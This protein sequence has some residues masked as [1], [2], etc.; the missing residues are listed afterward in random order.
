MKFLDH[1]K[2][3]IQSGKGG[4]GCLSFRRE[5][6]IEFGGP[7]GGD[8]GRGGDVWIECVEGLNTLI[9]YRFQQ[10]YKAKTGT[11]GMGKN[12]TGAKGA[13]MVLKVPAG[14]QVYAEDEE[15]LIADLTV[16]GMRKLLATGGN[17]GFGNTRFKSATNRA[18]RRANPGEPSEEFIL[19]LQLK[20]IADA[21]LVGLP[22]A[23]KSTF[24]AAVTSARP[25]IADYP[26]TTLTPNLGVV[27]Y[28]SREFVLADI[29]GLIEGAHEGIGL[30]DQFLAH[31][32]RCSVILHL[33]DG[34]SD[35][36][37]M[38][39]Q[40]IRTE[41][42][43]HGELLGEKTEIVALNK[44]DSLVEEEAEEKA[45]LLTKVAGQPVH[46]LSGVSG[47]GRDDILNILL[48]H[49]EADR[50]AEKRAENAGQEEEKWQP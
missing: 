11:Q 20:L 50:Q 49:I 43:N 2:V 18:P 14:T 38:A 31:I 4:N 16:P 8:G 25:K 17:G 41:L 12:R 35:D 5:K 1:A 24:L 21:G 10:H 39:Y 6:Y 30:G 29:P 28:G 46:K 15:T 13:D 26:F 19:H 27:R 34:T 23:G 47:Q 9:D 45:A 42:C 40:T 48:N 22:N 36:V 44:C 7:D 33:V 3:H 32:E 37:A